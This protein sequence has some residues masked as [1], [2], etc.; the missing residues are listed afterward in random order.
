MSIALKSQQPLLL[1]KTGMIMM[2]TEI[3]CYVSMIS[4]QRTFVLLL[5]AFY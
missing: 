1:N 4:W 5:K 2:A 3:S